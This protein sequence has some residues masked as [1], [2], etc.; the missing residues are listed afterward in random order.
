VQEV[1]NPLQVAT[2]Q[3]TPG[4]MLDCDQTYGVP[5]DISYS[6]QTTGGGQN[7][8]YTWSVNGDEVLNPFTGDDYSDFFD[9]Y[10][11]TYDGVDY[12]FGWNFTNT[13]SCTMYSSGCT[14]AATAVVSDTVTVY[15]NWSEDF[16]QIGISGPQSVTANQVNVVYQVTNALAGA[17][18]FWTVPDDCTIVSGNDGSSS[19][20]INWGTST[21]TVSVQSVL[22]YGQSSSL[23][24]QN[25]SINVSITAGD[26]GVHKF[27]PGQDK[28][29][30]FPNPATSLATLQFYTSAAGKYKL[31]VIDATGRVLQQ[32]EG[33]ASKGVN[34]IKL[35][36][37]RLSS[38]VYFVR[39]TDQD[40]G[41]RGI[42]LIIAR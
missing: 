10:Y 35:D 2:I 7:P 31:E 16:E 42:K 28:L 18:Y 34:D 39:F 40:Y 41:T 29:T 12:E 13:I 17:Q 30:V 5:A 20:G 3:I 23:P 6:V 37:S 19:V 26:P 38:A 15:S 1:V 24:S 33:T 14:T 21:G 8:S 27:E 36:L 4:S 22:C 11:A 32:Q 9:P 25:A